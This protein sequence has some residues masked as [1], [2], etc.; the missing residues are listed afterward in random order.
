MVDAGRVSLDSEIR[1][2][3]C[4]LH[5]CEPYWP[6]PAATTVFFAVQTPLWEDA[7]WA[8]KLDTKCTACVHPLPLC[9]PTSQRRTSLREKHRGARRG[10]ID[11]KMERLPHS[12]LEVGRNE[13]MA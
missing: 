4:I 10:A 6:G 13:W 8:E 11:R 9:S 3:L 12:Q 2:F 7:R 1:L 5:R